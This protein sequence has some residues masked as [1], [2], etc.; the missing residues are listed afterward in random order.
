MTG[1]ENNPRI[2]KRCLIWDLAEEDRNNLRKY[3]DVIKEPDRTDPARYEARLAVC[4]SCEK[5]NAATCTA[6]GCYV[7]FRAYAKNSHCPLKKW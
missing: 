1:N 2:C 7:E 5:M 6:C 4:L 3:L